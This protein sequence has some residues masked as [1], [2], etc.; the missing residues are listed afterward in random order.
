[1]TF[2]DDE[3]NFMRTQ[4]LAR[5]ATVGPDGQPDVVP[6]GFTFDGTY[7]IIGGANPTTTRRHR[8]VLA[9]ND[10]IALVID[11][12][13]SQQPWTPRFLRIYGTGQAVDTVQPHLQIRPEISWS[14]NLGGLPLAQ[15]GAIPPRRTVHHR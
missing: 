14:W 2:T 11:D 9:G 12:L 1:M 15:A 13:V 4:P 10:K 6:V 5:I 8:N 7:I 3:I